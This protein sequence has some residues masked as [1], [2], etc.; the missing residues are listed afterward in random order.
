MTLETYVVDRNVREIGGQ[1]FVQ[2]DIRP[3]I[4]SDQVS[5]F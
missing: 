4:E 3:P 2:P 5:L 1:S